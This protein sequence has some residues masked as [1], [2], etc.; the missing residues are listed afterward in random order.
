MIENLEARSQC[1]DGQS[2]PLLNVDIKLFS[3]LGADKE[4]SGVQ[5]VHRSVLLPELEE[6]LRLLGVHGGGHHVVVRDVLVASGLQL[7]L[8]FVKV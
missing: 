5:F 8:E 4:V 6:V 2:F 3:H 1:F 7:C